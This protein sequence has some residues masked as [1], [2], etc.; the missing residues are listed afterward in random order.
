M[1][2]HLNDQSTRSQ[3]HGSVQNDQ[4]NQPTG[5]R[6]AL[7]FYYY[8][9]STVRSLQSDQINEQAQDEKNDMYEMTSLV[10]ALQ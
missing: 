2:L 8:G 6:F 7:F 9:R 4:P 1:C 10:I 5:L 3:S